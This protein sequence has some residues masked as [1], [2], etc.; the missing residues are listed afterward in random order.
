MQNTRI[1]SPQDFL[2]G[3]FFIGVGAVGLIVSRNYPI[4]T[5]VSM[6]MGYVPRFLLWVLIALGAVTSFRGV[7]LSGE[8][9]GE[10]KL[11]PL[12][13]VTAAFVIFGLTIESLGIFAAS[14]LLVV[15]GTFAGTDLRYKEMVISAV[16]LASGAALVFVRFLGLPMN[17][18]P[19][20]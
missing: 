3:L 1:K 14:A 11:R 8:P 4:G 6:G 7:A 10:W 9:I 5:A 17:I 18:W 20:W 15:L 2:A 13:L 12:I 19:S 16:L